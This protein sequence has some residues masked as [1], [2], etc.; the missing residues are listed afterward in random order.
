VRELFVG[1]FDYYAARTA[2]R[3]AGLTDDE[4]LWEPVANCW[5]IRRRDGV[6]AVDHTDPAPEPAPVTTIAW[7]MVHVA[8]MLRE[9]GLRAVA[10]ERGPARHRPPSEI[11]LTASDALDSFARAVETW[12][13][14]IAAVPEARL[15]EPLGPEAGPFADDVVASFIEHIHDEFI[16]HTAEI[17]LLR[18]LYANRPPGA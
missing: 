5:S 9:H 7:R 4:Y 13:H 16:H 17:G 12:K 11:P 18:D 1:W 3:L 2:E 14:D 8:S 10:F 6:A 15:G